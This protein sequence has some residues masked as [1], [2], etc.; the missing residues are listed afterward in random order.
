MGES[1]E[2][3]PRQTMP[4][5]YFKD[6]EI[7]GLDLNLVKR[8]DSAREI[9]GVPFVI[10]SGLRTPEHSFEV[11]GSAGDAHT[12]GFAVDLRCKDS[13]TRFLIMKGLIMAGFR[14]IG[15]EIDHIHA[16]IDPTL[17]IDVIWR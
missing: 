3:P 8:L 5:K 9:A 6:K 1:T 17:D 4:F 15:D 12:R 10:T 11:G 13:R 2:I 16:D 14:R 7:V